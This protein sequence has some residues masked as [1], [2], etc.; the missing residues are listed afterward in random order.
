MD[1]YENADTLKIESLKTN[2]FKERKDNKTLH[3]KCFSQEE[4]YKI[5]LIRLNALKEEYEYKCKNNSV[6][7]ISFNKDMLNQETYQKYKEESKFNTEKLNQIDNKI[8]YQAISKY[9]ENINNSFK[10]RSMDHKQEAE[11]T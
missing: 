2:L 1:K 10:E 6:Q 4:E 5:Q 7:K 8:V 3:E 9:F 11:K